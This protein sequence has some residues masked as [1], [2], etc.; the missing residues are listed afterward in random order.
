MPCRYAI[1]VCKD[2]VLDHKD[3][4]SPVYIVDNYCNTYLDDFALNHIQ[5]KDLECS[6]SCFAPLVQKKI[7]AATKKTTLKIR[8]EKKQSEMPL[9]YLWK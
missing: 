1:T 8:T 9:Y 6:I 3:F 4:N 5:I 2:Q 7:R